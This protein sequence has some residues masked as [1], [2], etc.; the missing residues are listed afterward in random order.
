[1]DLTRP[2]GDPLRLELL[3][4]AIRHSLRDY[5][6]VGVAERLRLTYLVEDMT[7][8]L[9]TQLLAERLPPQYIHHTVREQQTVTG[10]GTVSDLHFATWFD[11]FKATYAG[12]WWMRWRMWTVRERQVVVPYAYQHEL[13]CTHR[14]RIS[15]QDFWTY[16]R[17]RVGVPPDLGAPVLVSTVTTEPMP[18]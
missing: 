12:R 9:S 1:M 4:V 5:G 8:E 17:D 15:V 2:A 18:R 6:L 7:Y 10:S 16:P 3:P 13:T 14:V 11:H